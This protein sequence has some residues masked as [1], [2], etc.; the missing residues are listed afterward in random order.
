MGYRLDINKYD[1]DGNE[2]NIYYGTKLIGY[3][4]FEKEWSLNC[5]KYLVDEKLLNYDTD[6]L[7]YEC[8]PVIEVTYEQLCI[9]I[10]LYCYDLANE[11]YKD[12][13]TNMSRSDFLK[14]MSD[15]IDNCHNIIETVTTGCSEFDK[16]QIGWF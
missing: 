15:V 3:L 6:C 16:I 11:C 2:T 14:K 13:Q 5:I 1:A 9:F 7:G 8:S 4:N 12:Y 10:N